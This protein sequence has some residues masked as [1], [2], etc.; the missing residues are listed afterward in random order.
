MSGLDP[1]RLVLEV[2]ETY[3]GLITDAVLEELESLRAMGVLIALD[4][5]GTGFNGLVRMVELPVDIVKISRGFISGILDDHRYAAITRS[6]LD[7][8]PVS[9]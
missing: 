8:A 2:T 6:I 9:A 5:V 7:L 4:D 3:A 1:H